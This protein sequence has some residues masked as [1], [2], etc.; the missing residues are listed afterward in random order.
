VQVTKELAISTYVIG[1]DEDYS[2]TWS[3]ELPPSNIFATVVQSG[4]MVFGGISY[5]PFNV[6]ATGNISSLVINFF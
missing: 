1:Y 6:S 3:L 5:C 4:L 2:V